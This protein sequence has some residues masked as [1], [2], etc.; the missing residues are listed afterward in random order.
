[1]PVTRFKNNAR[2]TLFSGISDVA[3]SATVQPGHGDRFPVADA[4]NIFY[5][6][7]E[8]SSKNYEIVKVTAR[9]AGSDSITIVRAQESTT[10]RAFVAGA[11][12]GLRLTAGQAELAL[13]AQ[14]NLDIH[15]AAA[16][17]HPQYA[18]DTDLTAHTGD[19]TAAHAASAISFT[20]AGNIAST[21]VQA[22]L[23]E[24]D[25]EKAPLAS[26]ALT[27][28]PTAPTPATD[29]NSTKLATTAM[30]QAALATI[31]AGVTSFNTR[32]G[33]VTLAASDITSIDGAGSGIDADL[34]D[35]YHASAFS[36][37]NNG[38]VLGY[39][40]GGGGNGGWGGNMA[41]LTYAYNENSSDFSNPD[42]YSIYI[43]TTGYYWVRVGGGNNVYANGSVLMA[44]DSNVFYLTAG[45][46]LTLYWGAA[47]GTD[48]GIT[49][50]RLA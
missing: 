35:G 40:A 24:L 50:F 9:A 42:G 27:G 4:N 1:M 25:T 22:A 16:D 10:A 43:N 23:E 32:A 21:D 5:V 49:V 12:V 3:T 20:P 31:P 48:G 6:T 2:T 34:L 15:A 17:P 13:N 36:M 39:Y 18:L 38:P 33:A 11:I 26:P 45:T 8:D 47:S 41:P 44:N 30:V 37:V 14:A 28:T 7:I 46:Y 29:D 19:P